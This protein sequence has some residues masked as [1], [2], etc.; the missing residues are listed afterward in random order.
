[1]QRKAGD[2]SIQGVVQFEKAIRIRARLSGVPQRAA[3]ADF[4]SHGIGGIAEAKS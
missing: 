3:E 1:V 4:A 2:A